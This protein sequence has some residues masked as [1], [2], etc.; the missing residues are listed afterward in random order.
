[1]GYQ[2]QTASLGINALSGD[3]QPNTRALYGAGT[4][5]GALEKRLKHALR[6]FLGNGIAGIGD[7]YNKSS[8]F[9][10]PY[11]IDTATLW[12]IINRVG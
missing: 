9:S 7:I 6:I 8:I 1:M 10:A 12:R 3:T 11:D 4:G 2:G 5:A